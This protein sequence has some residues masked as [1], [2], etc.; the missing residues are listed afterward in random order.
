MKLPLAYQRQISGAMMAKAAA[1]RG[2]HARR[3][4]FMRRI[5]QYF[6]PAGVCGKS[7]LSTD[8]LA[9]VPGCVQGA[10]KLHAEPIF[11]RAWLVPLP[12]AALIGRRTVPGTVS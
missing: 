6:A 7:R 9:K 12:P 4:P 8:G 5:G 11:M 10:F 3:H 1:G 2:E